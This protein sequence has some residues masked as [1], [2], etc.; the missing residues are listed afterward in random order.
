MWKVKGETICSDG[1]GKVVQFYFNPKTISM[2]W[3]SVQSCVWEGFMENQ[4]VSITQK[5][6]FSNSENDFFWNNFPKKYE[7]SKKSI[8][9]AID[10]YLKRLD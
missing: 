6:I 4:K 7:N 9:D 2:H 8:V 3:E 10:K 1:T 5:G